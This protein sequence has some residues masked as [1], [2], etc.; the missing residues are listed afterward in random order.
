MGYDGR[1]A[2]GQFEGKSEA[3]QKLWLGALHGS[4]AEVR[5][6]L[7]EGADPNASDLEEMHPAI[8][9]ACQCGFGSIVGILLA[10]GADPKAK[11]GRG[12]STALSM[13]AQGGSGEA[14]RRLV[15][16]G[17]DPREMAAGSSALHRAAELGKMEA[18]IAL[19]ELGADPCARNWRNERPEDCADRRGHGKLGELLGLWR[20]ASEE[21]AS[22][23]GDVEV[24][25]GRAPGKGL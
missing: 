12:V 15:A 18:A 9:V 2:G 7:Q 14:I 11:S 24:P 6:A 5:A 10:A 23:D 16:A 25:K 3:D 21:K 17:A 1:G 8:L 19:L 22:L 4:E 13:A 20:R